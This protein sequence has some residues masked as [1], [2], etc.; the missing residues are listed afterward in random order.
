MSNKRFFYVV[1][2]TDIQGYCFRKVTTTGGAMFNAELLTNSIV[3][4]LNNDGVSDPVERAYVMQWT[5]FASEKDYED[6]IK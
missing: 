2:M 3:N 1:V 6:F 4:E 5:E